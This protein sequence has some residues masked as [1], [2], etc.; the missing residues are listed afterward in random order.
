MC[1]T[2][3]LNKQ[4]AETVVKYVKPKNVIIRLDDFSYTPKD[5]FA[6]IHKQIE[7]IAPYNANFSFTGRE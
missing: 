5:E 3:A 4:L 2:A 6:N 7:R 1:A